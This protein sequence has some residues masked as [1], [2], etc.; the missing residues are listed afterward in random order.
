MRAHRGFTL[1]ELLIVMAVIAILAAIAMPRFRE[2][3]RLA[4]LAAMKADLRNLV[5]SAESQY[6]Q[7]GSYANYTAPR[8]SAGVTLAFTPTVGGWEATATHDALP[9]V[10]CRIANGA[11][12]IAFTE[13]TCQ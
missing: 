4:Y 12:A 11:N 10:V 2:S 8:G 13:P 7:D 1:L 3:K 6:S 9:G 5:S